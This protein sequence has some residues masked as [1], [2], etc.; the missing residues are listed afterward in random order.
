MFLVIV[1]IL[2]PFWL[3]LGLTMTEV[4]EIQAIFGI[5]LALFEIPTGYI[6]DMWSRKASI[7]LGTFISG[8]AFSLIPFAKTYETLLLYEI[9]LALGGSFVSGADIAIIYDSLPNDANRL[10]RIGSLHLWGLMGEAVAAITASILILWSFTP[11]VWT[12]ALVGWIPFFVSLFLEEPP[13]EK[14]KHSSPLTNFGVVA[15]YILRGETILRLIFINS[16]VW[17]LSSF[18]V[19]WLLQPYWARHNVPM[20]YFGILWSLSVFL[21]AGSSKITHLLEKR[22]GASGVLL[23]LSIAACIGYFGMAL[24]NSWLGVAAGFLFYIN[25]GLA[26]VIF[27]D[28]FNWKIPSSFRAT[29]NSMKS[30]AFRLS[31]GILGPGT[32]LLIDR[33]GLSSTLALGGCITTALLATLMLPLCKRIHEVRMDYIPTE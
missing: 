29:A 6:A 12:Q 3:S 8:C 25:R 14:M 5:S 19:V 4:L 33:Y 31:Y 1:P 32:G 11:I 26:A 23:T 22:F 2:V 24:L 30:F 15:N 10:K 9:I 28:A 7:M 21:A 20:S 13:L 16:I 18:C 27:T 17:G